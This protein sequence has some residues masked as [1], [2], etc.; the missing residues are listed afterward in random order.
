MG[1]IIRR[2][3]LAAVAA[4]WAA[5]AWAA[6]PQSHHLAVELVPET[7]APA[8]GST[9]T[10]AISMTPER[11]WHGYWKLPGD[12]GFPA[13]LS[14]DL[15][16]GATADAPAYPVPTT[17]KISGLMNHVFGKPY[18]LL[19]P[20]HIPSGLASGTAFPVTLRTQYLV[21][22]SEQCVPEAAEARLNLTIGDGA[23]DRA[24]SKQ[25]DAWRQALPRPIGSPIRYERRGKE[26]R[27]VF[28]LAQAVPV[29]DPHLFISTEDAV[30]NAAPQTFTRHG[31]QLVVSTMAGTKAVRGIDGVLAL[32]DGV[33]LS[34]SARAGAQPY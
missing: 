30:T 2:A 22:T 16:R 33:G 24:R 18:A 34:F 29:K 11:G 14:W 13:K 3:V 9:M 28:P 8:P 25:F 5:S 17:L 32:G 1:P 6:A 21:C 19:A 27:F 23:I 20:V 7:N 15:P 31:D 12:A 26:I 4:A 10:V